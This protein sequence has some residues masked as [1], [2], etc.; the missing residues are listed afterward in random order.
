MHQTVTGPNIK[1]E[2]IMLTVS[3][4]QFADSYMWSSSTIS[5]SNWCAC[6]W[7]LACSTSQLETTQ[8]YYGVSLLPIVLAEIWPLYVSGLSHSAIKNEREMTD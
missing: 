4:R 2:K 6:K 5:D 8:F 3:L 1:L 7:P